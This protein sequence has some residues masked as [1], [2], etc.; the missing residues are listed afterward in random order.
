M[1]GLSID[2]AHFNVNL[3]VKAVDEV[4]PVGLGF[5]RSV[6]DVVIQLGSKHLAVVCAC[7][8]RSVDHRYADVEHSVFRESLKD[9]LIAY[10]VYVSVR[11]AHF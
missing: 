7:L 9:K 4:Q 2:S 3:F 1:S 11:Y 6:D 8:Y 10:S 5:C